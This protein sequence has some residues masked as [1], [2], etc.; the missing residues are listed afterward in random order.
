MTKK[1][2]ART[3]RFRNEAEFDEHLDRAYGAF[4]KIL[5]LVR[6]FCH[7]HLTKDYAELCED[8]TWAAYEEGLP[9][10]SGKPVG[11][12]SAIVHAIGWVNFLHDPSQSPHI[13]SLQLAD[14]FGVSQATMMAKAK[15]IREQLDLI[16]SDPAWCVPA[17]LES[18]PLVWILKVN[19][20]L[21]DIRDAPREA[22]E[23]AYRVGLIPYIPADRQK[24]ELQGDTSGKIIQFPAGQNNAPSPESPPKPQD[25]EPT[26]FE[27]L[28][29]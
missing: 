28:K 4:D 6:S 24:P 15:I 2:K 21:M 23:E 12:A 25:G 19:G 20:V 7:E 27:G 18:N 26:L 17:M 13:T 8:L 29:E 14:G 9:L 22:Q 5:E 11:W 3:K 1:R 16:R 10:E